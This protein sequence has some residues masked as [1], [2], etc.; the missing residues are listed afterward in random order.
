MDGATD[1][2]NRTPVWCWPAAPLNTVHRAKSTVFIGPLVPDVHVLLLQTSDVRLAAQ[3]PEQFLCNEAKGHLL[4]GEK[5]KS[6]SQVEA[7]LRSEQ[8]DGACSG[9]ITFPY[10]SVVHFLEQLLVR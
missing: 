7:H 9:A 2:V 10:T 5:R 4:G 8:T 1:L 6:V 3:K